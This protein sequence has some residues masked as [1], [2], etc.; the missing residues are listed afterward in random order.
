MNRKDAIDTAIKIIKRIYFMQQVAVYGNKL[1]ALVNVLF[2][3]K[4]D[5][6]LEKI[7][8]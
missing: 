7:C 2:N 8:L 3:Q 1:L 4:T 5:G 6:G